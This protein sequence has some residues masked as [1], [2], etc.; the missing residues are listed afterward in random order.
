METI[1]IGEHPQGSG[2]YRLEASLRLPSPIEEVFAFF[3]DAGNLEQITPPWMR[4]QVT[5]PPP[6]EMHEGLLIDYR[7]KVHG[8]PIGW[9]SE[10]TVWKPPFRFVDEQRKG[11]YRK[12]RHV[13]SF[14]VSDGGTVVRDEVDYEVPGG[15][16]I[17]RLFVQRDLRTIFEYRTQKL[18]E[19]FLGDDCPDVSD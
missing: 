9:Q 10:I 15:R 18:L 13:H 2:C 12:W 8:I 11:P 16:F 14:E 7:L 19:R 17:N 5:T 4:F 3:A 6:I 1:R